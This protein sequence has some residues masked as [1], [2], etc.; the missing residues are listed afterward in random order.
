M[1][2][3]EENA[4][5][6]VTLPGAGWACASRAIPLGPWDCA[7]PAVLARGSLDPVGIIAEASLG[8]QAQ[9]TE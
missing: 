8:R 6:Y 2:R 7:D 5:Q 4:V 9:G 3:F 1:A